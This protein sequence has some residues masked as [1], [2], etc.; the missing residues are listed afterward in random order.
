MG[1]GEGD[2]ARKVLCT[3]PRGTGDRKRGTPKLRQCNELEEDVARVGYRN[4]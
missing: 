4:W 2:P 1:M 3:Q